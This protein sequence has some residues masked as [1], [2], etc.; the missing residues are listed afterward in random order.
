MKYS[1]DKLITITILIIIIIIL[2]YYLKYNIEPN[3]IFNY[4]TRIYN[5][6]RNMSYDLR[7]EPL[8]PKNN[9]MLMGSSIQPHYR[10]KC[11]DF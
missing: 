2:A 5:S 3:M 1:N 9:Y 8:I 6:T 11:L 4:P 7:C 10:E